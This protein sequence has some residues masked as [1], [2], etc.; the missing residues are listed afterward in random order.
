MPPLDRDFPLNNRLGG[1]EPL[2]DVPSLPEPQAL[3]HGPY[4]GF[5]YSMQGASHIKKGSPC[6]DR[7]EMRYL[8]KQKALIAAIADGL[9]SYPL[10]HLGASCAVKTALDVVEKGLPSPGAENELPQLLCQAFEQ[11]RDQVEQLADQSNQPVAYFQSTLTVAVYR[12]RKLCCCHVGD[13]GVVAQFEDGTAAMVTERMKG[14]EAS[15]VYPLQTGRWK[16][17]TADKPVVAFVMA[18]DGVLD[19]FVYDP[20]RISYFNGIDYPA[21]MGPAVYKIL[22]DGASKAS[23]ACQIHMNTDSFRAAVEDDLTLVAVINKD[24]LARAEKPAFD[25]KIWAQEQEAWKQ[26]AKETLYSKSAHKLND[27]ESA[28]IEPPV[29]PA[30]R[31]KEVPSSIASNCSEDHPTRPHS[32]ATNEKR[33]ASALHTESS[34]K[35]SSDLEKKM[36]Q[37][38]RRQSFPFLLGAAVICLLLVV[39]FVAHGSKQPDILPVGSE[40][41]FSTSLETEPSSQSPADTLP[42]ILSFEEI[43][44]FHQEFLQH[45]AHYREI[46]GWVTRHLAQP[47]AGAYLAEVRYLLQSLEEDLTREPLTRPES[48]SDA[49]NE[50]LEV[51]LAHTKEYAEHLAELQQQL[52]DML[53]AST[54]GSTTNLN[55][56]AEQIYE[57]LSSEQQFDAAS[58]YACNLFILSSGL[59]SEELI[60]AKEYIDQAYRPLFSEENLPSWQPTEQ[61]ARI[62]MQEAL[63]AP[64]AQHYESTNGADNDSSSDLQL[65]SAA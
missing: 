37:L 14:E 48:G 28:P 45:Q 32:P 54:E 5:A 43:A 31:T 4:A 65:S 40:T 24:A 29:F 55:I 46:L 38:L 9:G 17:S 25:R 10:S 12:S 15:S 35:S 63:R 41:T 44:Q 49:Q 64:E 42:Q 50:F 1:A 58:Y 21:I 22:R 34:H 8:P 20:L 59:T 3:E 27:L 26:R 19:S 18:T 53:A 47:D 36:E 52:D 30:K 51:H 60:Q 56:L 11:A 57:I 6:Q 39:L 16:V 13:D 62:K 7:C 2:P 61:E 33:R 23:E